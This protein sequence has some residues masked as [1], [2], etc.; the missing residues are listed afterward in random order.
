MSRRA[1]TVF[2]LRPSEVRALRERC[3]WE[4]GFETLW[5]E[6]QPAFDPRD[7]SIVLSDELMGKTFRYCRYDND[8]GG[9]QI[10]LRRVFGRVI[11]QP[12]VNPGGRK[13]GR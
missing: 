12:F 3:E 1:F 9:Q 6:L 2:Y 4:G 13:E 11:S 7:S 5:N 8:Q 10:W